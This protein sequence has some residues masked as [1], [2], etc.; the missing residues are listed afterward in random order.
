[1]KFW[2]LCNKSIINCL[3]IISV[4]TILK[5][6]NVDS[7]AVRK[8]RQDYQQQ[9][10]CLPRLREGRADACV[11]SFWHKLLKSSLVVRVYIW[12][13]PVVQTLHLV[14]LTFPCSLCW[15]QNIYWK[16]LCSHYRYDGMSLTNA[17]KFKS[18]SWKLHTRPM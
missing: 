15:L 4:C 2:T 12:L 3:L 17:I 11:R 5:S 14:R 9:Q 18:E 6:R 16:F 8:P 1:M 10:F 7:S 13:L